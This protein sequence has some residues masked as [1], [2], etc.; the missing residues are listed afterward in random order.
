MQ[1]YYFYRVNNWGHILNLLHQSL[2]AEEMVCAMSS[3]LFHIPKTKDLKGNREMHNHL[4]PASYHRVTAV[5]SSQRLVNG[6]Q[7]Q[8]IVETL[9]ACIKN[10][11]NHDKNVRE[12]LITME[13]NASPEFKPFIK[14]IIKW[15]EQAESYLNQAKESLRTMGVSVPT[16]SEQQS[17]EYN[18]Y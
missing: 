15:Q 6:E 10:A 3:E 5:G 4:V 16:G 13:Q 1:P 2:Y 9:V 14:V 17:G 8:S 7:Q 18:Y 11:E 12:G